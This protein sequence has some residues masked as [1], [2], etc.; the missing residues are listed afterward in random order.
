MGKNNNKFTKY[1]NLKKNIIKNEVFHK[2]IVNVFINVHFA[3]F[4]NYLV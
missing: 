3:M 1:I 2:T 4:N